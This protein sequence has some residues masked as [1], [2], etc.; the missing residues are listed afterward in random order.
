MTTQ[1]VVPELIEPPSFLI[2]VSV[3]NTGD[4]PAQDVQLQLIL[5]DGFRTDSAYVGTL[6][7]NRPV[8]RSFNVTMPQDANGRYPLVLRNHYADANSYPFSM[9]TATYL[10]AGSTPPSMVYAQATK[11]TL[12][13]DDSAKVELTLLNRDA[14][15]KT[16]SVKFHLPNEIKSDVQANQITIPAQGDGK[17]EFTVENFAAL[18]GSTYAGFFTMEYDLEGVHYTSIASSIIEVREA[19]KL[20]PSNITGILGIIAVLAL[21]IIFLYSQFRAKK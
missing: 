18:A 5:P 12:Y 6:A 15:A 17:L 16:V 7:P 10:R 8:T 19:K 4:E 13:G 21:L 1:I 2:N 9:V 20:L 11:A 14:A 3:I